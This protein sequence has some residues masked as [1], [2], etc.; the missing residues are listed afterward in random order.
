MEGYRL[1]H[2]PPGREKLVN[3]IYT[4]QY[5]DPEENED[6]S[7]IVLDISPHYILRDSMSILLI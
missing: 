5:V 6:S 2:R 3:R 1:I 4:R 7:A